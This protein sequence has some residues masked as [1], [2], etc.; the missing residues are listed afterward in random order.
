MDYKIFADTNVFLDY[1]LKRTND[2]EYAR[3]IFKLAERKEIKVA[4]SSS[5]L[6]NVL[7]GLKQQKKLTQQNI[8]QIITYLLDY[9]RLLH[10]DEVV[11]I[12]ALS[13]GFTDLEDAIQYYTALSVKDMDY[14]I[15]SNIK[16]YKKSLPQLTVITPKQFLA[17]Q[18][19]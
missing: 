19:K 7:Y 17:L 15:T 9:T 13:S 12:T 14:F 8:I 11:F 6:V 10:S 5:S 18:S 2:W 1:L 16:D 3:N 4:T